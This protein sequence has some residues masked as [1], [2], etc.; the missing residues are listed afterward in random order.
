[1]ADITARGADRHLPASSGKVVSNGETQRDHSFGNSE[2]LKWYEVR[3]RLY[4]SVSFHEVY[5][6][7]DIEVLGFARIGRN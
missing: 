5:L 7:Y 6:W 1:M 2:E 4:Q 3:V